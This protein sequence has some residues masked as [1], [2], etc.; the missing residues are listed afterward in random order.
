[1]KR[2]CLFF[3]FS[4]LFISCRFKPCDSVL[5][6]R[7][8]NF[9]ALN[10]NAKN[11][12]STRSK[13]QYMFY[14]F[15]MNQQ[16]HSANIAV[17]KNGGSLC[18][19][20]NFDKM[21][22]NSSCSFEY[23]FLYDRDFS[24]DGELARKSGF[25]E[26]VHG[27]LTKSEYKSVRLLLTMD[28]NKKEPCG[29]FVC[30][31]T[32]YS[33]SDVYFDKAKCGWSREDETPFFA[34]GPEGGEVDFTFSR[35]SFCNFEN[36]YIELGLSAGKDIGTYD[37]QKTVE[38]R[39]ADENIGVRC[40]KKSRK[41]ILHPKAFSKKID[42][43]SFYKNKEAV[44]SVF[45]Y[46]GAS[47]YEQE[48]FEVVTV[49]LKTDLGLIMN[50]P[51]EKWRNDDYELFEWELFPGVLFIDFK[52]YKVQN[53]FFTR[54]AYFVEK[55]GY[56][57]TLVDDDFVE[58]KHGYNAHDYK[59]ADLADFFTVAKR[60]NFR[61]NY[62]E[63]RLRQILLEN[64]IIFED[65]DGYYSKENFG[66]VVSFSRESSPGLRSTFMAHESWH[67]IYFSDS[68]FRNFV[69][70]QYNMFDFDSMDF[71]KTFWELQ[72]GL[73]YDRSD[74]Y[75]M[76]NE[77]MAYHMQQSLGNTRKYFLQI[78]GRGSVQRNQKT[79]AEY[80]KSIE[81]QPFV[82]ACDAFNTYAFIT[83]GLAAGRVSLI[84]RF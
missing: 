44:E 67:G 10:K 66:A 46:P 75:L 23:G 21:K 28:K 50:W 25:T 84:Y 80:V 14:K 35:A 55:A 60:Q 43:I 17:D 59:A 7:G 68:D 78:C 58:N 22:K 69:S 19:K 33:L 9:I 74:E 12:K 15:T 70:V 26:T 83:W 51:Q 8:E 20:L 31:D 81:A 62:N 18:V 30:A 48:K 63:K 38:V 5:G 72:P 79:Q 29:F 77:F 52:N 82:D 4:V 47:G 64:K 49:P 54:L 56:K 3:F 2:F 42:E 71:L 13:K 27:V 73:G 11:A 45:L 40:T 6:S 39:L 36:S 41:T 57:G 76:Q 61:L 32:P 65:A 34:Y 37:R 1:M 24:A 16:A 53:E